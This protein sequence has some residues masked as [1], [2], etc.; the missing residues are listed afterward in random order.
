MNRAALTFGAKIRQSYFETNSGYTSWT[1][2]GD[3]KYNYLYRSKMN[4]QLTGA[5]QETAWVPISPGSKKN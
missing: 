4:P 1:G 2:T 5:T 3:K